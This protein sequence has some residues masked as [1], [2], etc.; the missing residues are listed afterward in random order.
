MATLSQATLDQ[1]AMDA[2]FA[3]LQL[4]QARRNVALYAKA[5]SVAG[6]RFEVAYDRYAIGRLTFDNL[7]IAQPEKDQAVGQV[8]ESLRPYWRAHYRL[9]RPTLFDFAAGQPIR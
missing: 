4:V 3:A 5:D 2:H 1:V 8:A 7:Y 9:R 6:R